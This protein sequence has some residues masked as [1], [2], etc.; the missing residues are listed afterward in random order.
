MDVKHHV[1]L[2]TVSCLVIIRFSLYISKPFSQTATE[3]KQQH[4]F[5]VHARV[6]RLQRRVATHAEAGMT[7]ERVVFC[8]LCAVTE[9]SR[10]HR[11]SAGLRDC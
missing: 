6:H 4:V 11:W 7:T 1:Y 3:S 10:M 9:A 2:L 5:R 8:P